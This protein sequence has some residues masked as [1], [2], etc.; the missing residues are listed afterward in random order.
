MKVFFNIN[1]KLFIR[2]RV[3]YMQLCAMLLKLRVCRQIYSECLLINQFYS[4]NGLIFLFNTTKKSNPICRYR[5][6]QHT[7]LPEKSLNTYMCHHYGWEDQ[8]DSCL[9]HQECWCDFF[10]MWRLLC[11]NS[12]SDMCSTTYNERDI[13]FLGLCKRENKGTISIQFPLNT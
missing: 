5:H 10:V 11:C 8:S 1:S 9:Q 6:S 4:I 7:S 3:T 13:V 2:N 12:C